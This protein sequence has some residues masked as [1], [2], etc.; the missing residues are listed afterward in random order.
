M[1]VKEEGKGKE[2]GARMGVFQAVGVTFEDAFGRNRQAS[3]ARLRRGD[4]VRVVW[5]ANNAYDS[6]AVALVDPAQDAELGGAHLGYLWRVSAKFLVDALRKAGRVPEGGAPEEDMVIAEGSVWWLGK[7]ATKDPM[8]H[9][10]FAVRFE[11]PRGFAYHCPLCVREGKHPSFG[12]ERATRSHFLSKHP[13]E[14]E[15]MDEPAEDAGYGSEAYSEDTWSV[16][17]SDAGSSSHQLMGGEWDEVKPRGGKG[18]A[19][20]KGAGGVLTE[21]ALRLHDAVQKV[22]RQFNCGVHV[23]WRSVPSHRPVA[24]CPK[25]KA[26]GNDTGRYEAVPLHLEKGNMRFTCGVC[27]AKWRSDRALRGVVQKCQGSRGKCGAL[28]IPDPD[29]MRPPRPR[30]STEFKVRLGSIEEDRAGVGGTAGARRDAFRAK[31]WCGACDEGLCKVGVDTIP[32][33]AKHES[34]GST[35]DTGSTASLGSTISLD[36]IGESLFSLAVE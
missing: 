27:S 13:K 12:T 24:S 7:P 19:Y 33:S 28:V 20:A 17:D 36:S 1:E 22:P 16:A 21:A 23:F 34:T 26:V 11:V 15:G 10:G 4:A 25:C 6:N 30:P 29:S 18:L 8:R 35:V 3:I 9:Q 2:D 14:S 32:K 31:H 5:E